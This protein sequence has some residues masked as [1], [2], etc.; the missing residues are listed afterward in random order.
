MRPSNRLTIALAIAIFLTDLA[1]ASG[2]FAAARPRI[3]TGQ[4]LYEACKV[5]TDYALKPEG[6]TPRRGLYCQ[7]FIAGYFTSTKYVLED[8]TA[9]MDLGAPVYS[10]DC[11]ALSGPHSY[12]ELAGQVLRNAEWAPVLLSKPAIELARAAFGPKHLC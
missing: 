3:A 10:G 9:K 4:D 7:Q 8:G 5:L 6:P 2:A 1:A 11:I 12:D